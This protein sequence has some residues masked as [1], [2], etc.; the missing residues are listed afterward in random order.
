MIQKSAFKDRS[1][2]IMQLFKQVIKTCEYREKI[3]LSQQNKSADTLEAFLS[4]KAMIL[5]KLLK[6]SRTTKSLLLEASKLF[7]IKAEKGLKYLQKYGALP[8]PLTAESVARFFRI[9]P[10]LSKETTGAF[11]GELGK[12]VTDYE[13]NSKEFHAELLLNYVTL[14]EFSNQSVL[15][16]MRIFLSAFRLPGEAQQID[17]ILV[18]F[19]EHCHSNCK[20]GKLGIIQNAEITYILT[21]SIIML[22]TDRHNPNIK[23]DRKMTKEQFVR[24]NKN[25]GKDVKQTIDLSQEYLEQIFDSIDEYP[26]RTDG[27]EL[28]A[29]FNSEVWKDLQM[30]AH[31]DVKKSILTTV[32]HSSAFIEN[33]IKHKRDGD[34]S[35]SLIEEFLSVISCHS[36]LNLDDTITPDEKATAYI[37]KK[38]FTSSSGCINPLELTFELNGL[39]WILQEDIMNCIWLDLFRVCICI[40]LQ[41][42][43]DMQQS[44]TLELELGQNTSS[45]SSTLLKDRQHRKLLS[46]S[47]EFLMILINISHSNKLDFVTELSILVLGMCSG[48]TVVRNFVYFNC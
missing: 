2:L 19:S 25:Y 18:A 6:V 16:C 47:N 36:D 38:L 46:I 40:H 13:A 42:Y 14:F 23:A 48:M 29:T 22:N 24:N 1:I 4:E 34:K 37:A 12:D 10:E 45:K 33:L 31:V 28:A 35:S 30:Q 39:H 20:E 17:R 44:I 7:K 15:D 11:L 8:T 9:A 43:I 5:K 32:Q 27:H 41:K 21:F 3:K 26:I